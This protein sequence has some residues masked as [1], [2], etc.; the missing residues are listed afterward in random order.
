MSQGE[1]RGA[2]SGAGNDVDTGAPIGV[3]RDLAEEPSVG[4][5]ARIRNAIQRR[6]LVSQVAD[7]SW[8]TPVLVL[9]EYLKLIFGMFGETRRKKE[10]TE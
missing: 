8:F 9:L 7:L 6:A 2:A 3:L 10:E 1:T 4:F 5:L